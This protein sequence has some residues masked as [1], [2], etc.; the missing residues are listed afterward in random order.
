MGKGKDRRANRREVKSFSDEEILEHIGN[1]RNSN[2]RRESSASIPL[3]TQQDGDNS[4]HG[5]SNASHKPDP[6]TI[7]VRKR[8]PHLAE[9][10][11]IFEELH[12]LCK[13]HSTDVQSIS[14]LHQRCIELQQEC[15]ANAVEI[16]ELESTTRFYEK[17]AAKEEKALGE[18]RSKLFEEREAFEKDKADFRSM[19]EKEKHRLELKKLEL[20]QEHENQIK[21]AESKLEQQFENKK[22]ELLRDTKEKHAQIGKQVKSLVSTNKDLLDRLQKTEEKVAEQEAELRVVKTRCEDESSLKEH[23]RADV[24]S[25]KLKNEEL[26]N[27]FRLGNQTA[28]FLY[29]SPG[30]WGE[31]S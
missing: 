4:E 23:F 26:Q 16:Q 10:I 13:I 24:R 12:D 22:K 31:I 17:R 6:F 30:A 28:D 21:E 5:N 19:A 15:D 2:Q 1:S 3:S 7:A 14:R 18:E 11:H 25:Y 8:L 27:E 20:K 9:A 29:A